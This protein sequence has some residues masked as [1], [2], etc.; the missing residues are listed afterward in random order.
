MQELKV[1]FNNDGLFFFLPSSTYTTKSLHFCKCKRESGQQR[2]WSLG[3]QRRFQLLCKTSPRT[4]SP[5]PNKRWHLQEEND[6]PQTQWPTPRSPACSEGSKIQYLCL[7]QQCCCQLKRMPENPSSASC[8]E[9]WHWTWENDA[10]PGCGR[11]GGQPGPGP[12]WGSVRG[13]C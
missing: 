6:N 13:C 4:P 7:L 9:V 12:S 11:A 2:S 5:K 10:G 1:C 8:S 3:T